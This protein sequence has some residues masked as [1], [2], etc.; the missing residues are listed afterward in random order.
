[1]RSFLI[2]SFFALCATA[3]GV[4][5]AGDKCNQTGFLCAD[6]TIAL[7][8]KVGVW[9]ALPCKGS[10]G[11]KRDNSTIKCDMT[12]NIE[13]DNCAS[14]AEGKGL[15]TSDSKGTL[16]CRDGKLVKTNT[17]RTCTVTGDMVVCQ[18]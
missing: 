10:N 13:N 8:C 1:M 6:A 4:P 7:E 14:T 5:K 15:C 2:V 11:C 12:G 3:C 16:E 9:T 17:C 18:P